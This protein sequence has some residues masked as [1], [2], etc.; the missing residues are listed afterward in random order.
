VPDLD[1]SRA[2]LL[3]LLAQH[4]ESASLE[5]V[6]TCDL[7]DRRDIVE[8]ATEIGALAARGGSLVVGA[9]DHGQVQHLLDETKAS[10]FDEATLRDKLGRY[11][12]ASVGFR[13]GRHQVGDALVVLIEVGAH[14]DGAAVFTADG[15]YEQNS[16]PQTAFRKGE[17]FVRH[18][19]RSELP[20]QEDVRQIGRMAVERERLWLD[21]LH[22]VQEAVLE[23]GR[24]AETEAGGDPNAR[25]VGYGMYS[26]MPTLRR[27]LAAYLAGLARAG[28]PP[29][30]ACEELANGS[31]IIFYTQ[32]VSSVFSAVNEIAWVMEQQR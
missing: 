21:Q 26:R 16:K 28:G 24:V 27:N 7:T 6:A 1:V 31:T 23:I 3:A 11:L 25:V 5:Y 10:L 17:F 8:L 15:T 22:R 32:A 30:P 9:D 14:P 29:L 13:V 19:T 2:R 18:G 12:P 20:A 4:A